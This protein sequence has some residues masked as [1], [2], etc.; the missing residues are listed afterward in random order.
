MSASATLVLSLREMRLIL[1]RLVQA[2][3]TPPGL[4]AAVREC[5][6]YSA[7]LP[8]P[9]LAG[10]AERIAALRAS[11]PA[12]L[13][14]LA[15]EPGLEVDCAGQHAW[16]AAHGLLDLAVE[17]FRLTGQGSVVAR[18]L[19]SADELRV[20]AGLAEGHGLHADVAPVEN[21]IGLTL[22]PRG[23]GLRTLLD[24]VREEGVL[25][26]PALWWPLYHASHEALAP[27]SFESRRHA[28]TIRVEADGRIVGRNDEDET[29]LAML[30]PDP[31]RLVPD[32][33][34]PAP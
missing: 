24:A 1:E 9:G 26:D 31:S 17:R 28:G 21:G 2:A 27:D 8:G 11:R 25:A 18:N 3:G 14:I 12:P 13:R 30:A 23:A 15:E 6:L 5:A 10:F 19:G 20:A 33:L 34:S 7:A 16:F 29:D 22:Q 32:P 4:L